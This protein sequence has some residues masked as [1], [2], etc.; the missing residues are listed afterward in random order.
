MPIVDIKGRSDKYVLVSGHYDSWYER[1]DGQRRGQCDHDR[2]GPYFPKAPKGTGARREAGLVVG[3]LDGK[4]SGSNFYFDEHWKDLHDNC[5]AISM[6]IS[7]AARPPTRFASAAGDGGQDLRPRYHQGL[8]RQG[9]QAV[10]PHAAGPTSLS[11]V[12]TI[13]SP[14]CPL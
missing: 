12:R 3:P 11:G 10:C 13:P 9:G 5:V 1:D 14:L 6:L 8:H 2:D 7:P 4:Y